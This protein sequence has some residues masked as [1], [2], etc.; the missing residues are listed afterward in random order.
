[1]A[2]RKK[3]AYGLVALLVV[4]GIILGVLGG[5]GYLSPKSGSSS[6]GQS[7]S[8]GAVAPGGYDIPG[9]VY[10]TGFDPSTGYV[11][12]KTDSVACQTC[13]VVITWDATDYCQAHGSI[14]GSSGGTEG[15]HMFSLN[16]DPVTH[17]GIIK[18]GLIFNNGYGRDYFGRIGFTAVIK[19]NLMT[20]SGPYSSWSY[21]NLAPQ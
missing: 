8:G 15:D 20:T 14:C 5:M 18:T 4:V 21:V 17:E 11:T 9:S 3:I 10:I 13:Y 16:I 1:M 7:S 19:N 12:I 2:S 6:S